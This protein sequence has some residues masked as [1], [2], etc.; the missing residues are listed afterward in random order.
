MI[1]HLKTWW[2]LHAVWIASVVAFFLP[3]F[4]AFIA[5]H[6]KSLVAAVLALVISALYTK[7]PGGITQ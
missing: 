2:T 4:N 7:Q 6:P 5:G 1:A 3:S